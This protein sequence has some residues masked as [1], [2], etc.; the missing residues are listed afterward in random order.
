[1]AQGNVPPTRTP[2]QEEWLGNVKDLGLVK[3]GKV[4]DNIRKMKID[5]TVESYNELLFMNDM[6]FYEPDSYDVPV[7]TC[8]PVQNE[9]LGYVKDLGL[10]GYGRILKVILKMG[11]DT[12]VKS[13]ND[14]VLM[15]NMG[16]YE[17]DPYDDSMSAPAPAENTTTSPDLVLE[18][19][20][21][22]SVFSP[23]QANP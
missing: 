13:Y 5:F 23:V 19:T 18:K 12:T 8:T 15:D 16:L 2:V 1:M 4:L 14:L 6:C 20:L 17:P 21:R 11:I 22:F 3:Y 9:W 10:E 7:P